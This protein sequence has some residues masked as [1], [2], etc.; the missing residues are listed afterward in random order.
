[1][2]YT[3]GEMGAGGSRSMVA[4]YPGSKSTPGWPAQN[5]FDD[6]AQASDKTAGT[7]PSQL[8]APAALRIL[9]AWWKAD[10]SHSSVWR[11][12]AKEDFDFRAGEQWTAE[13]RQLLNSQQRP[14]IVFNRTI[15][16][17][18]AVAGMEINGRHEIAY[19]PRHNEDTAA[20]EEL[21]GISK[22]MGDECDAED[23][24]SQAFDNMLTCGMG[25][26]E[27][28]L[29]FEEDSQG[30]YIEEAIDP[31]EMYWDRTCLRRNL[32][33]ARRMHRVRKL[34]YGD[35]MQMFP[36]KTRQQL[37][38][39][40][41][42]GTELET[43]T[44]TLEEKRKRE[45]NTTD[46]IYDDMLEVTIVNT[47]W[48]EREVYYLV[49]DP[50]TNRVAELTEEQYST[51]ERRASMLSIPLHAAK[52]TRKVFKE[53]FIGSDILSIGDAAIKDQFK[54]AC[55][56]GELN[57][58][59]GTWFGLVRIMRDPQMWSN[60]WL[61]QTL[62]ILNTTAKGGIIAEQDTFEDIRDVEE[63]WSRP[64]T[65]ILTKRGALS[66]DNPK[67][68]PR[69]GQGLPQG[70]IQLMQF[71]ITAIRDVTGINLEL[72]GLKDQ[73]QPGIL[74][75]QRKQAGMTVL[76]TMFDSL[77][78]YRK[79]VGRL[80]LYVIQNFYSDGRL[81]RIAGL[82]GAKVVPILKSK[83]MGEYNVVVDDTPTSPNQKEANWAVIQLMLPI[84]KDQLVQ[85]PDLLIEILQY[86]P[87]PQKL[88]DD[89]RKL[90][91][92]K[93]PLMQ[94]QQQLGIK[95]AVA[96]TDKDQAQAEL[97][98][99]QAG[100]QQTTAL[101][102]I[103][104]ATHELLRA[105]S[106]RD[107]TDAKASQARMD[108]AAKRVSTALDALSPIRHTPEDEQAHVM[109]EREHGHALTQAS[110]DH[111]HEL[112]RMERERQHELEIERVKA[113]E[114]AKQRAHEVRMGAQQQ[115]HESQM[116]ER[117]NQ[118]QV[119]VA[120]MKPKPTNGARR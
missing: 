41:A 78:R 112:E 72:L 32:F 90:M 67:I 22:W 5:A 114:A 24:Q 1:M 15:T 97:F 29:D 37:D 21:S 80:R 111:A 105:H 40:W 3:T 69:P 4:T 6:Q 45:E 103:A 119:Q 17:L 58:S 118:T 13:D 120:K 43:A 42:L 9:K 76:A 2:A 16:M 115:V 55:Q 84:F 25:W 108:A 51:Y 48:Y 54:W 106:E 11:V 18:R 28:R 50:N 62:H 93:Q 66:G 38:A 60:K 53:A 68:I 39:V 75:A 27:S 85:Q 31:I 59:R 12:E 110:V 34:P 96:K 61:S 107:L 14:H 52:L 89:M 19:L 95:A 77:R 104:I 98:L 46:T 86:S 56:T 74:E 79:I 65:L 35:A 44:K 8:P 88:I 99:A 7:R 36:G 64:D 100:K 70:H 117:Q 81:A 73:N 91:T 10:A 109:A 33:G 92:Q 23:E 82:Q 94:A 102:D 71:A 49:A 116:G 83:T 63:K 57:R 26:T 113:Q 101:Y 20:N 47:Q 87:L 30:K